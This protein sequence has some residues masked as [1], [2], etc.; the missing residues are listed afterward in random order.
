M[1]KNDYNTKIGELL[2]VSRNIINN[3]DIFFKTENS[4]SCVSFMKDIFREVII[5]SNKLRDGIFDLVYNDSESSNAGLVTALFSAEEMILLTEILIKDDFC[6]DEKVCDLITLVRNLYSVASSVNSTLAL[7]YNQN[8]GE[9]KKTKKAK[10]VE[11]RD[12]DSNMLIQKLIMAV[13]NIEDAERLS[14]VLLNNLQDDTF[15]KDN[16]E[17]VN[18]IVG[19]IDRSIELIEY[20]ATNSQV[21]DFKCFVCV[22]LIDIQEILSTLRG[23]RFAICYI[24]KIPVDECFVIRARA[25]V[26]II[27]YTRILIVLRTIIKSYGSSDSEA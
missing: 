13:E 7:N 17:L 25:Q 15:C 3:L 22:M 2:V 14:N 11:K 16:L 21:E 19:K 8:S 6:D 4:C 9:R 5:S 27:G 12:T 20:F 26:A 10:V 23:I 18:T 1:A 24:S